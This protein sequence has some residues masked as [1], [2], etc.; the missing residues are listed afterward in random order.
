MYRKEGDYKVEK[1]TMNMSG[2]GDMFCWVVEVQMIRKM[3]KKSMGGG[4]SI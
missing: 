1:V 3:A 4:D 2:W